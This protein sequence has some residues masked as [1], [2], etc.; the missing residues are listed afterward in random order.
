M[1]LWSLTKSLNYIIVVPIPIRPINQNS[2]NKE[3]RRTPG[4]TIFVPRTCKYWYRFWYCVI[5]NIIS[6]YYQECFRY[7]KLWMHKLFFYFFKFFLK[8]IFNKKSRT[9]LK[10]NNQ[11][12]KN[13]PD[14]FWYK[15]NILK[16][17]WL[18]IQH[19]LHLYC[20]WV[21]IEILTVK[22]QNLL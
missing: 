21:I 7:D 6:I 4:V 11:I 3:D 1:N 13:R 5:S 9:V 2:P 18:F 20:F 19:Q 15:S 10:L 12:K 22:D 8:T 17:R 14:R 16:F